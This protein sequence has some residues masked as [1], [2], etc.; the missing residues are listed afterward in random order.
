MLQALAARL[1]WVRMTCGDWTRV[2][3]PAVTTSHG[4]T[5]VVLDPPY[6]FDVRK[7]GIYR[8]DDRGVAESVSAWALEHGRDPLLRI[9]VAGKGD[10]HADLEVN[11]WSRLVWRERD[12]ET[13]WLSPRCR[14][15]GG[16]QTLLELGGDR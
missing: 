16:Q 10:E 5:G 3:S 9:A 14:L 11:G 13:L 7:A 8:H 6:S 2:L 12:G 4:L 15:P 1:R